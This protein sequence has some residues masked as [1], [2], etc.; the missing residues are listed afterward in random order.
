[1]QPSR[2]PSDGDF[3]RYVEKLTQASTQMAKD[4][5]TARLA[6]HDPQTIYKQASRPPL[7]LSPG[8]S[9]AGREEFGAGVDPAA[10]LKS[11]LHE[12][13]VLAHLKWLVVLWVALQVLGEIIQAASFF[14]VP[15][16]LAYIAWVLVTANHRSS[17]ALFR[18]AREWWRA[19]ADDR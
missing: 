18:L 11:L 10:T 4:A 2:T 12:F 3:V 5:E 16:L 15:A 6:A 19:A 9:P 7:V 13:P 17:G 8:A 1:M 14:L